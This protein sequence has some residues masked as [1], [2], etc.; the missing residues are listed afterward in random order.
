MTWPSLVF[1]KRLFSCQ[2]REQAA[3]AVPARRLN[4]RCIVNYSRQHTRVCVGQ[5][6]AR[7]RG[8]GRGR[9]GGERVSAVF[10][11]VRGDERVSEQG[12]K[13][14]I[15]PL[16]GTHFCSHNS[17]FKNREGKVKYDII[18]SSQR[19]FYEPSLQYKAIDCYFKALCWS[20]S[21]VP[22]AA[23]VEEREKLP[24]HMET[25][26]HFHHLSKVTLW[27]PKT[28]TFNL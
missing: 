23:T 2:E 10:F 28:E 22:P 7:V 9:R 26:G 25:I 17:A 5:G 8:D 12:R 6:G 24:H 19:H 15:S 11:L 14:I 3:P 4:Y 18:Y 21:W 20:R 1:C 27:V 13:Y 16:M